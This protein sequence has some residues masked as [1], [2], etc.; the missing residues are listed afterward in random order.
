MLKHFIAILFLLVFMLLSA[1]LDNAVFPISILKTDNVNELVSTIDGVS[2][3]LFDKA[4][5]GFHIRENECLDS[6]K[7]IFGIYIPPQYDPMKEH[8]L[9][10]YLHGGVNRK[11]L[12]TEEEMNQY[13]D[14]WK[15]KEMADRNNY[16]V[17][18][19]AGQNGA[20]WWDSVGTDN[21]INQIKYVKNHYNIDDN[22]V[23]M[24]GFSDGASASFYFAMCYPSLFAGFI[25]LSGHAGVANIDGNIQTYFQNLSQ[26]P[27]HVVNTDK[28]GLYPDRKMREIMKLA[29]E[30]GA[31]I[32]YKTYTGYGHDFD[33]VQNEIPVIEDFINS[34]RR[35]PFRNHIEWYTDNSRTRNRIDWIKITGI[36]DK[37]TVSMEDMGDYNMEL[38][39]DRIMLGFY[40]DSEFEGPGI[41]VDGIAGDSTLCSIMGIREGDVFIRLDSFDIETMDDMAVYKETKN[42]GDS[43]HVEIIRDND[44]LKLKGAYPPVRY[45]PLFTR[46]NTTAVCSAEFM[47]NEYHIETVNV[48]SLSIFV[49]GLYIDYKQPVKVFINGKKRYDQILRPDM[50]FAVKNIKETKDREK[51]YIKKLDFDI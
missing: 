39:D 26:R 11:E 45:Y 21:I 30:A 46:E 47:G 50:G 19:P 3:G 1:E 37:N 43:T 6:V 16:I 31:N 42:R 2:K 40:P 23:F 4:E 27:M 28:D 36:D 25:P 14:D 22:A 34:R 17:L 20:V 38:P 7:R 41:K 29:I 35:A 51:I 18:Y 24:T 13:G 49:N 44:T 8:V 5:Q 32:T 15:I 33:Y 9:L 10:V 12:M 48:K